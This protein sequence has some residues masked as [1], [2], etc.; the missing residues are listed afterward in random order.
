[1]TSPEGRKTPTLGYV[2]TLGRNWSTWRELTIFRTALTN[3]VSLMQTEDRTF[4]EINV[5]HL[6]QKE[7]CLFKMLH[8]L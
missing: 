6:E 2:S 4:L 7:K 3:S 5:A 8:D 1:M